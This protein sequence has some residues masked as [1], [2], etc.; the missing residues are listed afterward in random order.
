LVPAIGQDRKTSYCI[1][2]AGI[3]F[4]LQ[5]NAELVNSLTGASHDITAPVSIF[6]RA[7]HDNTVPISVAHR[8]LRRKKDDDFRKLG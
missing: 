4:N 3:S 1:G 6:R 2:K 8:R 5:H 7:G